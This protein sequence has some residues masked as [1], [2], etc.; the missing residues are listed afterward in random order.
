MLIGANHA[1]MKNEYREKNEIRISEASHRLIDTKGK[2]TGAM[3]L[4]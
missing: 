3:C 1:E 4:S 2:R